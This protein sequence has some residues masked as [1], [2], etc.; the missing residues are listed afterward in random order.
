[1]DELL[2]TIEQEN[3]EFE[4]EEEF[5]GAEVS[6]ETVADDSDADDSVAV[7]AEDWVTVDTGTLLTFMGTVT[8]LQFPLG[9]IVVVT[10]SE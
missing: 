7:D 8:P 10:G 2:S 5:D 9:A 6:E 4:E 1:M 3:E